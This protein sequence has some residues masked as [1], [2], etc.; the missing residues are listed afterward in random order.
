M[1][2]IGFQLRELRDQDNFFAPV[3]SIGHAAIIATGPWLFTVVALRLISVFATPFASADVLGGVRLVIIYA[4]ALALVTVAPIVIVAARMVGDAIYLQ[5]YHRIKPLFVATLLVT[6]GCASLLAGIAYTLMFGL[7]ANVALAASSCCGLVALIWVG[8]S[9]CGAVRDYSGITAGFLIGLSVAVLASVSA[10]RFDPEVASIIWAFNIG[11]VIV[12]CGLASR[13]LMTFPHPVNDVMR[14][15]LALRH[16]IVRFWSLA[17]GGLLSALALWIDK[18]I[19][20]FGPAGETHAVGLVHAPFYDSA[21]FTAC[22]VV[23]PALAMFLTHIETAFFEK[24][25]A[26]YRA[27]REHATLQQIERIGVSLSLTT[28]RTIVNITLIQAALCIMTVLLAPAIMDL[29]DLQFR[30]VGILRLGVLGALFQFVFFA[31][32]SLLL[33][34]ERYTHFLTLQAIFL[35]LQ[36]SLTAISVHL[37][38]TYYGAGNLVACVVSG[39]MA[40]AVLDRTLKNVTFLTFQSASQ[41]RVGG[42]EEELLDFSQLKCSNAKGLRPC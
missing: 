26:Y 27:I 14:P 19:M 3:A 2:G 40:V 25:H 18:L 41:Q 7:A 4:F 34:F 29:A 23:I 15:L 10:A 42:V 28:F 31:A 1:A 20:W 35:L 12:F 36:G 38:T 13:V 17:L 11:L 33:F 9:F 16:G 21:M 5:A 22:L 32:T 6:G 39:L 8:L 37:G 24:Y 30:Q